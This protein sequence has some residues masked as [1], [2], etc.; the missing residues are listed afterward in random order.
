MSEK[1]TAKSSCEDYDGEKGTCVERG[2]K[3]KPCKGECGCRACARA[4]SDFLSGPCD[5]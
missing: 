2:C 3:R 4:Y 1:E 5:G